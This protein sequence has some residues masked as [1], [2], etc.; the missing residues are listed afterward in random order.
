MVESKCVLAMI[1]QKLFDHYCFKTYFTKAVAKNKEGK[2]TTP[3]G[4]K[5]L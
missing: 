1:F 4:N 3:R 2:Q 5:V